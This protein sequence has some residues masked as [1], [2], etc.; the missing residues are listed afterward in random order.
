MT[1]TN[2]YIFIGIGVVVGV[3]GLTML[4]FHLYNMNKVKN[5]VAD[6]HG[7]RSILFVGDSNTAANFSYADK[8]K[9]QFPYLRVKKI[10]QNGA[11]TDWMLSQLKEELAKNKYDVVVVLS[12]SNDI[13]A[14][15]SIDSAKKNMAS[16]YKVAH[17]NGSKVLAVAPP[18]KNWY[19]KR[20]EQKQK[21]LKDLV[22][23]VMS[24]NA[25]YK[26]NF[27]EITNDKKYFTSADGYL[28]AQSPAHTLLAGDV[29]KELNLKTA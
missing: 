26:I 15:N 9:K 8:L 11:K 16:M 1:K 21:L 23:W 13:Y 3:T 17:D 4:G 18:N 7:V 19:E 12:G 10:A 20:T 29:A 22:S 5:A 27:W 2:K 6:A 14:T 24:S 28:H 25:D